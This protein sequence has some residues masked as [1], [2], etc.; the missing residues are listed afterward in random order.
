[1]YTNLSTTNLLINSNHICVETL[2]HIFTPLFYFD[3]DISVKVTGFAIFSWLV[4]LNVTWIVAAFNSTLM[5]AMNPLL[6]QAICRILPPVD[7][8][9]FFGQT[10]E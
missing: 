3:R 10:F 7:P 9:L 6:R 4:S 2:I 5:E 1:M 8:T